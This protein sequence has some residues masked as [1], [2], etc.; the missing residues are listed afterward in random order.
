MAPQRIAVG[1]VGANEFRVDRAVHD[2]VGDVGF[3]RAQLSRHALC[4]RAQREFRTCDAA[5]FA[6]PRTAAVAPVNRMVP[7]PRRA[8]SR[9]F[10]K[11]LKQPISQGWREHLRQC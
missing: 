11:P 3:L 6:E 10:R 2:D 1:K 9:P 4:K 8:T 7:R 5:K